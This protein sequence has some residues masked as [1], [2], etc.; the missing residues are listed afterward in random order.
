MNKIIAILIGAGFLASCGASDTDS[1][2]VTAESSASQETTSNTVDSLPAYAAFF[3]LESLSAPLSVVSCEV[4][5]V[6]ANC[7]SV[8]LKG[9]PGGSYT[10]GP[11]CPSTISDTADKGGIWLTSSGNVVH[12][13][14]GKFITSLAKLYADDNWHMF[15]AETGEVLRT[16]GDQCQVAANPNPDP[17]LANYCVQCQVSNLDAD[18]TSTYLV[19]IRP[20]KKPATSAAADERGGPRG[21]GGVI[22]GITFSGSVLDRSAPLDLIE[23]NYNIAPFDK[24]GGHINPNAGYHIHAVTDGCFI[25]IPNAKGHAAQIGIAMDGYPI[26][27]QMNDTGE[28]VDLDTCRGHSS[29]VDLYALD[30]GYHYH[31]NAPGKNQILPCLSGQTPQQAGGRPEGGPPGDGRRPNFEEAAAKL[32]VPAEK[33]EQVMRDAGGPQADLE[34]VAASLGVSEAELRE[35]LP[36]R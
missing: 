22:A 10:V 2:G 6:D 3:E 8:S 9:S 24:C 33:L 31:V 20:T 34:K 4:G 19:P 18:L 25:E 16:I 15:D 13:V 1:G 5:D 35:V 17:A 27:E 29:D 23:G 7:L 28:P 32:G 36:K 26:F 21:G 14:D 12:S 11:F 30:V